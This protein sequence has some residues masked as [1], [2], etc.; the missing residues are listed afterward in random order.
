MSPST[1]LPFILAAI[2]GFLLYVHLTR[3]ATK[4]TSLFEAVPGLRPR[5]IA[6]LVLTFSALLLFQWVAPL[7]SLHKLWLPAA[8]IMY[9]AVLLLES[10]RLPPALIGGLFGFLLADWVRYILIPTRLRATH[11]R[12]AHTRW[13][14]AILVLLI[15][16]LFSQDLRGLLRQLTSIST[17]FA[18][19]TLHADTVTPAESTLPTYKYQPEN[20]KAAAFPDSLRIALALPE[21]IE[22][23]AKFVGILHSR[24]LQNV[25][26]FTPA[27]MQEVHDRHGKHF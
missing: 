7:I 19:F 13:G 1:I 15:I 10:P 23:D 25:P 22:R 11:V 8:S 3:R 18:S 16:G 20:G 12:R 17:P 6:I 24:E 14:C 5:T 21:M 26:D 2:V 27:L 4:D 9:H